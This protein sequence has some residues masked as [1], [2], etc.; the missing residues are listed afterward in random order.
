MKPTIKKLIAFTIDSLVYDRKNKCF[1]TV[2]DDMGD[3]L[4]GDRGEIRLDSDGMQ[5]IFEYDKNN[6]RIGY[7]LVRIQDM[8]EAY[9]LAA[10]QE[11]QEHGNEWPYR[12]TVKKE[13]QHSNLRRLETTIFF[14]NAKKRYGKVLERLADK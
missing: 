9:L 1:A 6:N 8:S 13:I 10:C 3:P 4:N 2:I 7:N 11:A 5:P 12:A 14:A